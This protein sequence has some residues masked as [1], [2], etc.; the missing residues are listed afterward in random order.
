MGDTV[1]DILEAREAGVC[2]VGAAWGWHG[3]ERLLRAAPDH[4][5]HSP[6]DL[7]DLF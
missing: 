4:L 6:S 2:T 1:G 3:A 7:L 5:A